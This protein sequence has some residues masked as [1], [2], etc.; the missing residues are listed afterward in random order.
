MTAAFPLR[1]PARAALFAAAA[2]AAAVCAL[3]LAGCAPLPQRPIAGPIADVGADVAPPSAQ[4]LSPVYASAAARRDVAER[5]WQ[6]V[7][8]RFHDPRMNGVDW[9]AL[10]APALAQAEAAASDAALYQVLKAMVAALRDPH[11]ELLTA[12]EAV[13]ARRFVAPRHGAGF[14]VL[15][16]ALVLLDVDAGSPAAAAGLRAGDVVLAVD[17]TRT[18]AAFLRAAAED[19]ATRT[20]EPLPGDGPEALPADP[21]DAAR[22]R[23][24][25]AVRRLLHGA[26]A[27]LRLQ[28]AAPGAP[29]R[30]LLLT[31]RAYARPAAVEARRLDDGV[32]LIRFNRFQPALQPELERALADAAE[33]R[34]LVIDLRGNG[35]GLMDTYR[36]FVGRFL[37]AERVPL[38]TVA[39]DPARPEARRVAELRVAPSGAPLRQPLAVLIDGR[40]ASAAELAAVTLAEQR[41]ALLV[42]EPTC[43]CAAAVRAEY[44]LPDGGGLRIAEAG[45]VSARGARLQGVPTAPAL[46]VLPRVEDLQAGRDAVLEQA[47]RQLAARSAAP[48]GPAVP[49]F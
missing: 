13:D 15:D 23:A 29:P 38:R 34:A 48:A 28:V 12:R 19:G 1:P 21:A 45:F 41:D 11:T 39:R 26:A 36:W 7:G 40:T 14:A 31:A 35:G 25:R 33:A 17:G 8:T 32:A 30:E 3:A 6:L 18:D 46:R 9:P 37:D 20:L 27:P 49:F 24:L 10:R 2:A 4:A 16:D 42:G 44:V 43:G 47:L 5:V 22:L